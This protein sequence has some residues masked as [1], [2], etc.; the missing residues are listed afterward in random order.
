MSTQAKNFIDLCRGESVSSIQ[1][2]LRLVSPRVKNEIKQHYGFS[3]E[4][5]L[6]YALQMGLK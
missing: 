4:T 3:D 6:T 5:H 1:Q 2:A